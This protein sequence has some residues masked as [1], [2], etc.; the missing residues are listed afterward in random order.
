[1]EFFMASRTLDELSDQVLVDKDNDIAIGA[2]VLDGAIGILDM[3][4]LP[5]IRTFDHLPPQILGDQNGDMAVRTD[6]FRRPLGNL[7]GSRAI[8]AMDNHPRPLLVDLQMLPAGWTLE[9][10]E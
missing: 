7:Q 5:A 6:R 8:R 9:V 10:N 3:D 1:M 4:R 2:C